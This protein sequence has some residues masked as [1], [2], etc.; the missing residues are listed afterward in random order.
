[1]ICLHVYLH[2]SYEV[3]D[4]RHIENLILCVL[5][6]TNAL[7]CRWPYTA[8]KTDVETIHPFHAFV[9]ISHPF[10][11]Q[12]DHVFMVGEGAE[13]LAMDLGVPSIDNNSLV[14][15][16]SVKQLRREMT[17]GMG[18]HRQYKESGCQDQ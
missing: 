12:T 9:F 6:L 7:S 13:R 8:N 1:M 16:R 3:N 4:S 15:E 2:V 11:P 5:L 17:Y 18:I 10:Y 14:V